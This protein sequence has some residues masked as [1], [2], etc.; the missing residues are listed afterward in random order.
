MKNMSNAGDIFTYDSL[1]QYLT[2]SPIPALGKFEVQNG[3][4]NEQLEDLSIENMQSIVKDNPY[5]APTVY[6]VLLHLTAKQIAQN[7]PV[8]ETRTKDNILALFE[9]S[10]KLFVVL[11]D[12]HE[13]HDAWQFM[14]DGIFVQ[15]AD[16]GQWELIHELSVKREKETSAAVLG[17]ILREGEHTHGTNICLW[18]IAALVNMCKYSLAENEFKKINNKKDDFDI[19]KALLKL[20]TNT[21]SFTEAGVRQLLNKYESNQSYMSLIIIQS[22]KAMHQVEQ[23]QSQ[24]QSQFMLSALEK[25]ELYVGLLNSI[26]E[27]FPLVDRIITEKCSKVAQVVRRHKQGMYR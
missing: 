2:D 20:A 7:E 16:V 17:R 26:L 22:R 19:Y 21:A 14:L 24:R 9:Q 5:F 4:V 27:H 13:Y 11:K 18:K 8:S 10:K 12:K 1:R 25:D 23:E 6:D 3:M 15:L